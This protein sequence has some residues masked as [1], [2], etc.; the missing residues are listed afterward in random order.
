VQ[1][2][3]QS[4]STGSYFNGR[5]QNGI[6]GVYNELVS[7]QRALTNA[8]LAAQTI[9][10]VARFLQLFSR[11]EELIQDGVEEYVNAATHLA[12]LETIMQEVCISEIPWLADECKF[13]TDT[14][15]VV[16]D[17]AADLIKRGIAATN[18]S[19]ILNGISIAYNL[20]VMP[21]TI[22]SMLNKWIST[23]HEKAKESFDINLLNSELKQNPLPKGVSSNLA[24]FPILLKWIEALTDIIYTFGSSVHLLEQILARKQETLSTESYLDQINAHL[25]TS[26]LLVYFWKHVSTHLDKELKQ[27]T[28]SSTVLL[29]VLQAGYPKVLRIFHDLFQR[30]ALLATSNSE[31]ETSGEAA[32]MKILASFESAYISRSLSRILEA[33]NT[34]FPDKLTKPLSKDDVDKIA[35][36]VSSE[37][38]VVKFNPSLLKSIAKNIS[39][40]IQMFVVKAES[41]VHLF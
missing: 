36:T 31:P 25:G 23:I 16:L 35:R 3:S 19:W 6:G 27:A 17:H 37:I 10:K 40:S 22:Y 39:K 41:L 29:Q 34:A 13:I 15:K 11:C 8:Q 38:D 9:R 24:I 26:S 14:R 33:V 4:L 32:V 12:D 2:Q 30:F 5:I 20:H 21:E 18:Q 1:R 7:T 28:K